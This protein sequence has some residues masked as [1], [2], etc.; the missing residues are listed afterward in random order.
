MEPKT[1]T[2]HESQVHSGH[3][4]FYRER[5]IVVKKRDALNLD[6]TR[7]IPRRCWTV[8]LGGIKLQVT[9]QLITSEK[10]TKPNQLFVLLTSRKRKYFTV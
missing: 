1:W 3:L 2:C 6:V 7:H 10:N 5:R 9:L 8:A 4:A